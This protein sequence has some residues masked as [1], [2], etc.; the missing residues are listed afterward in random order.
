MPSSSSAA[1]RP[2]SSSSA[3][4]FTRVLG[5][6]REMPGLRLTLEQAARLWQMDLSACEAVLTALVADGLLVR[7]RDGAFVSATGSD[8]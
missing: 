3:S 5:E 4:L 2:R 6:Y 7:T 1:D 8:S